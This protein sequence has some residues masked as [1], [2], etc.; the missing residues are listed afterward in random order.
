MDYDKFGELR[1]VRREDIPD[2]WKDAYDIVG[3]DAFMRLVEMYS[4]SAVNFPTIGRILRDGR[5]RE[6]CARFDGG[7]YNQLASMFNLTERYIRKIVDDQRKKG[8]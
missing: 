8:G 6:I 3:H 7:N 5:N 4:G 2:E 1:E